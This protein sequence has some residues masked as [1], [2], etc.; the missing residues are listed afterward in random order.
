[1]ADE[2]STKLTVEPKGDGLY[3]F[4]NDLFCTYPLL[5]TT[6]NED[7]VVF[8]YEKYTITVSWENNGNKRVKPKWK[9]VYK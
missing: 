3:L 1:M 2:I 6:V 9:R 7:S 8:D 4:G 5:G